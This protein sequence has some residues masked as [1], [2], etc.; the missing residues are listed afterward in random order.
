M[1]STQGYLTQIDLKHKM[2]FEKLEPVKFGILPDKW[3]LQ[4]NSL[5]I[6]WNNW[7]SQC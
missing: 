1:L 5:L 7:L 3:L 6:N 4:M 2:Q